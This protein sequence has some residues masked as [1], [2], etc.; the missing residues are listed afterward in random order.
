METHVI[1]NSEE[2]GESN[3]S[4]RTCSEGGIGLAFA[5]I[6]VRNRGGIG[7]NLETAGVRFERATL[8]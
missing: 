4:V 6:E 8:D 5:V 1:T 2:K 7:C 3:F